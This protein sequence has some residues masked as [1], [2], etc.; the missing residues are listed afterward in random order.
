MKKLS[1]LVMACLAT[2]FIFA[3][4][5]ALQKITITGKVVNAGAETPKVVKVNFFD[6]LTQASVA[7]VL[8]DDN[9]FA[10]SHDMLYKQ[11]IAV[12]YH[13]YFINL[14]V[15]PGDSVHL[16]ID[17]SRLEEENF[18]WLAVS[19]DR[20]DIS[21]QLNLC[22]S[23][24]ARLHGPEYD[25]SLPP[26]SMINQVKKAYDFYLSALDGYRRQY[27]IDSEVVDWAE[28]EIKYLISNQI[29]DYFHYPNL[30]P[31]DKRARAKILN[32]PF[33]E[34]HNPAG[35]KSWLFAY[36]LRSY[37]V[38]VQRSDSSIAA[39]I[40][41]HKIFQATQKKAALLLQEP[42]GET[43]DFMLYTILSDV[44]KKYPAVLDSLKVLQSYFTTSVYPDYLNVLA[45]RN[46][47]VFAETPINGVSYL[48][49]TGE[50]VAVPKMDIFMYLKARY[51]GKVL[52]IDVYATWC[53]PCLE[54]MNHTPDLH[55]SLASSDVVFI[56]LC[57]EST[58]AGWKKLLASRDVKGENYFFT[59][60]ATKLFRGTYNIPGYPTYILVDKN[61]RL[62]TTDAPRPSQKNAVHEAVMGLLK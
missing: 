62:T 5:K 37:M 18:E 14:Y 11:N 43:R 49:D 2:A 29:I 45:R 55:T 20:A 31:Q 54:E 36:H 39:D 15:R 57:L 24:L 19:G 34:T 53:G 9:M 17:A 4:P 51:P 35:F 10:V 8:D 27:K 33:F 46:K 60:D 23:Y 13:K 38:S 48:A 40:N 61:G 12:N 1:L 56:N 6:P 44:A 21:S 3:Q 47:P 32:H 41:T 50:Q 26:E 42:A 25:F 30:S 59:P 52:Y 58:A 28:K 7:V 22:F 16:T